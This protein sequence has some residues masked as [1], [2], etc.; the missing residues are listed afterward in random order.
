[1]RRL[2]LLLPLAAVVAMG[3]L[4][5]GDWSCGVDQP[6]HLQSWIDAAHQLRQG[7]LYPRWTFAAAYNSGEPRFTFYP[8]LSW[9]L[10]SFLTMLLPIGIAAKVF[11][12]A[13]L[14]LAGFTAFRLV[15]QFTSPAQAMLC[16]CVYLANP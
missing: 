16:A 2:Q 12:W 1:M 15:G 11:V 9:E 8:P 6:F 4:L 5:F 10:G 13:V 7:V 14:S 3:P